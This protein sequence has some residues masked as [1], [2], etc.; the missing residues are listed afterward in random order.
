MC[1]LGVQPP[2][3]TPKCSACIMRQSCA[4]Y[5]PN[6]YSPHDRIG[7]TPDYLYHWDTTAVPSTYW[8]PLG[9]TI[10]LEM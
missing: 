9:Q 5:Q 1:N 8:Q 6:P 3:F 2:C 4:N 10:C 7:I